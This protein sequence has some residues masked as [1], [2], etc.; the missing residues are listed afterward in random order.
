MALFNN[1]Q[2]L[3]GGVLTDFRSRPLALCQPARTDP[4]P[5]PAGS[6]GPRP[7]FSRTR[8]FVQLAQ[9]LSSPKLLPAELSSRYATRHVVDEDS[10]H[11][12]LSSPS[13]SLRP[14]PAP[15]PVR[16]ARRP[17]PGRTAHRRRPH[18]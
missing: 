16:P 12:I 13:R 9:L 17:A 18:P 1:Y 15:G 5:G 11:A 7:V 10:S 2:L 14:P 4:G 8:A 6:L 3:R